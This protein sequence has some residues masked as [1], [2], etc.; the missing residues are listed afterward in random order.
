MKAT[1]RGL[2]ATEREIV[3]LPLREAS[4]GRDKLRDQLPR[5]R[6][7]LIEERDDNH[8]SVEFVVDKGVT[9]GTKDGMV[10]SVRTTDSDGVP[11][12]VDRRFLVHSRPRTWK[13]S[14]QN[15]MRPARSARGGS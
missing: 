9:A 3:S 5:A 12:E 2:T 6:V 15:R 10:A 1:P 4:P 8:G 13:L 7:T 14:R 11:V